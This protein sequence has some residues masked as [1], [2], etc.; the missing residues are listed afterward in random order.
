MLNY[1]N[2]MDTFGA[3]VKCLCTYCKVDKHECDFFKDTS[4]HLHL[5]FSY[6]FYRLVMFYLRMWCRKGLAVP[7]YIK[8]C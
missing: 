1:L 4:S 5:T 8:L 6:S 2:C 7:N 3:I